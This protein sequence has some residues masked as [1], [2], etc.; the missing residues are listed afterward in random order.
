MCDTHINPIILECYIKQ[1]KSAC[2]LLLVTPSIHTLGIKMFGFIFL[3]KKVSF[4][5]EN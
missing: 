5:I 2:G 1:V 3:M 4:V